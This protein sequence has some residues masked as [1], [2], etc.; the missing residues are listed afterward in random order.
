MN[1]I[2]PSELKHT[3][4][5]SSYKKLKKKKNRKS[6]L[7]TKELQHLKKHVEHHHNPKKKTH[8]GPYVY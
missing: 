8:L 4:F 5:D 6:T 1:Y 3:Q 7:H 2:Q